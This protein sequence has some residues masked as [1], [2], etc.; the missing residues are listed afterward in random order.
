MASRL[1][2]DAFEFYVS[3]GTDR[4][5]EAVARKYGVSKRAVTKFA[6]KE[7]WQRRIEEIERK[8][9]A[10]ADQKAAESLEQ[11]KLRHLHSLGLVQSKALE[12]LRNTSLSSAMD[13]V[14]ALDLAIKQERLIQGEPSERTALSVEEVVRNEH[15]RWIQGSPPLNGCDPVPTQNHGGDADGEAPAAQ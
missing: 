15:R 1:S 11:M 6:S 9:R 10:S 14:R 7:G 3:L 8:A 5:Y 2:S 4:S 12:V 13:A